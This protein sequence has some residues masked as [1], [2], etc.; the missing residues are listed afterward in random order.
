[1]NIISVGRQ[2]PV[3]KVQYILFRSDYTLFDYDL[4]LW[5]PSTLVGEYHYSEYYRGY[6]NLNSHDSVAILEDQNRRSN[7]ILDLIKLGRTVIIF[8]PPPTMFYIDTG[9]RS[10][11]GTGRSTK[12]TIHVTD[13]SIRSFIPIKGEFNTVE[14]TG[15]Q[16]DFKGDDIFRAFWETNKDHIYYKAY[17]THPIGRPFLFVH[18]TDRIVASWLRYERGNMLLMPHLPSEGHFTRKTDYNSASEAFIE[19]LIELVTSIQKEV[20]DFSLPKWTLDYKMPE[21]ESLEME[22]SSIEAEQQKTRRLLESKRADLSTV[23]RYKLLFS[24]KGNALHT[25]VI[26]VLKELGI[27]AKPGPAGRDDVILSFEGMAGVA[28]VKGTNKS[29][30]EAHAA[31]LEKW[32]SEYFA[33]HQ[34]NPKGF[35]IVNPFHDM[36]LA[37]RDEE[38]FP[39][40][41]FKYCKNREHCLITTTQLLGILVSTRNAPDE[42]L[43]IIRSLFSTVGVFRGFEDFNAFLRVGETGESEAKEAIKAKDGELKTSE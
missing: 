39:H 34:K 42:R 22:I 7:E 14:A 10:Y 28:E 26:E 2:F 30:A 40:Q 9:Q 29:A 31:Q 5:D 36:P 32:V 12:T 21:E 16:I 23:Q 6:P 33:E 1:M 18:G 11:S 38:P 24:S 17:F 35:L 4:V 27:D 8:V 41:M 43:K 19:T 25:Q 3:K 15:T 13:K 20:G 37:Q